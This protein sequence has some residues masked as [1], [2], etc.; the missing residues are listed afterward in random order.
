[1]KR[2][3]RKVPSR[4]SLEAAAWITRLGQSDRTPGVDAALE[5]WL[6]QHP[7]HRRNFEAG[8]ELWEQATRIPLTRLA[9]L[10]SPR[11]TRRPRF[12]FRLALASCLLTGL[13]AIF[14]LIYQRSNKIA[15]DVGQQL[16]TVLEDGTRVTLNTNSRL[17]VQFDERTRR[18]ILEAGE[19]LFEVAQN[20][21]RPFVV[22][23]GGRE[24]IALG[25][26]FVVRHDAG[27]AYTAVTLVE[28]KVSIAPID[29]APIISELDLPTATILEPGERVTFDQEQK[30]QIDRPP[31]EKVISW[32]R[33]QI[34]FERTPLAEAVAEVNRYSTRKIELADSELANLP[35]SGLFRT[36]D[37]ENFVLALTSMYPLQAQERGS[38]TVIVRA[39]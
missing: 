4:S 23:A 19:A 18:V 13:M 34:A 32:K 12:V 37:Q 28:G 9:N 3:S 36:G 38:V 16:A 1:M 39:P 21:S 2:S 20:K 17:T 15:T 6:A 11:E 29:I 24:V 27:R 30:V 31:L 8:S 7:E 26:Q 10:G 33:G 25:T 22:R 35:I 14:V 5:E